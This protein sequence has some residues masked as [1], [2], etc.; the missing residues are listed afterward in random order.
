MRAGCG[1]VS[2]R[3]RLITA[4]A[5]AVCLGVGAQASAERLWGLT[6]TQT[7]VQFTSAAPVTVVAT[8]P[9]TGLPP[10][11]RILAIAI[12]FNGRFVGLGSTG[13]LY[14]L[15]RLTGAATP[16][17]GQTGR[18]VA[19]VGRIVA[20]DEVGWTS[21]AGQ[22]VSMSLGN[23]SQA[24]QSPLTW[25]GHSIAA[26]G[27]M[28][29][30]GRGTV[31]VA[32]DSATDRLY[33]WDGQSSPSLIGPLGIDASAEGGLAMVGHY[34][35]TTYATLTVAGTLNL[36][37]LAD[38]G[39]A[40]LVGA[41]ATAPIT[42]LAADREGIEIVA[43]QGLPPSFT[44]DSSLYFREGTTVPFT[45]RRTGDLSDAVIYQVT[46]GFGH[47]A[48]GVDYTSA[49]QIVQFA[50]G[51]R[52]KVITVT[53]LD[54]AL[55]EGAEYFD[56]SIREERPTDPR[57]LAS[58]RV[59]IVDDDNARPTLTIISPSVVPAFSTTDRIT[60][61]G[62][63]TDDRPGVRIDLYSMGS[64]TPRASTTANPF[65]FSDVSIF[66]PLSVIA[67]DA[68]GA[69]VGV[70]LRV[71]PA[72]EQNFVLAEGATGSFFH[73]DLAFANPDA[74]DVPVT[75][76]FLRPDGSVVQRTLTVPATRRL[77][78]DVGHV[79]GL[80]ATAIATAAHTAAGRIAVE[81]TMRWG[82][83]GYGAS[84][85]RA[86][87]ALSSTWHFAEG[88]QGWF[89]TFLLL[90]NPQAATNVA[91]VRFLREAAGPVTRTY[92]LAPRSR[93][94]IDAGGIAE[95]ANTS[96][97]MEVTFTLPAAAERAMYFGRTPFW[98][99]GHASAGAI[100]PAT[101]W[102][103]A[104]GATGSFFDTFVLAA[105]PTGQQANVTFTFL[106]SSGVPITRTKHI[107]AHGRL[108]VN[109]EQ[110]DPALAHAAV[111]TRI[112][113]DVPIV[114]ER[115]QYWPACARRS[116]TRPV[117]RSESR[118]PEGGSF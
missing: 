21:D 59:E 68:D 51:E 85:E 18:I 87:P 67:W 15:D 28:H 72:P 42:S 77:T 115:S 103:L 81:R 65:T 80:E 1:P 104:E 61:S 105:N 43:P 91:T 23:W 116:E 16:L 78:L 48:E 66:G 25:P 40:S 95:L 56:L 27:W 74:I 92:T 47:A 109:I 86:A 93:L 46:T 12:S 9:L 37:R 82:P 79:P 22:R 100:G 35:R 11:E 88:S 33:E 30:A 54:D 13:R 45:L 55:R 113:S 10:G 29:R 101:E 96:F 39:H 118:P 4:I 31:R 60:V 90:V 97:G 99:G 32:V 89:S 41:I 38:T 94:T 26:I 114:V 71:V 63:V 70:S 7:L 2:T 73:T 107:P 98:S 14:V 102:F 20:F 24:R 53:L 36:Y 69:G 111:A 110:E 6:T 75:I 117:R 44:A 76:D 50:A 58:T 19:P 108:T 49:D 57:A 34:E 52:D 8:R 106:P 112:T 84:T 64:E 62:F 5:L 17:P 83:G 3:A